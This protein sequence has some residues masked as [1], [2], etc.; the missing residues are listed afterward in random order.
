[1]NNSPYRKL[2]RESD[3]ICVIF[4]SPDRTGSF[5]A[6]KEDRASPNLYKLKKLEKLKIRKRI[7]TKQIEIA[8]YIQT[9]NHNESNC[10]LS[11]QTEN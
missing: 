4:E 8:C 6:L 3:K 5:L 10:Q 2:P 9:I 1:L 11:E 7:Y